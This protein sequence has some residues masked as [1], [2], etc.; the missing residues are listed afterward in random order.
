MRLAIPLAMAA[1]ALALSGR[2]LGVLPAV[3]LSAAVGIGVG[4]QIGGARPRPRPVEDAHEDRRIS[5]VSVW[6]IGL[7]YAASWL[8]PAFDANPQ[9]PRHPSDSI[10]EM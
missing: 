5:R 1:L 6:F 10:P 8:L 3:L 2:G 4:V 7:V 9:G